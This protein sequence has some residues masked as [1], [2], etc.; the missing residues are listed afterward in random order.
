M[1]EEE[2]RRIRG[3]NAITNCFKGQAKSIVSPCL[4]DSV[5]WGWVWWDVWG[6]HQS[7]ASQ[8]RPNRG[9]PTQVQPNHH[10]PASTTKLTSSRRCSNWQVRNYWRALYAAHSI[11]SHMPTQVNY[12][13]PEGMGRVD[14][15]SYF[16][17][18]T[19]LLLSNSIAL[20][21]WNTYEGKLLLCYQECS[22]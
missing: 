21:T 4:L 8:E 22:R 7:W 15:H 18:H 19:N 3:F 5:Q 9:A 12:F 17:I 16:Q 11:H 13:A 14:M 6:K 10:R 20:S 2:R 1:Q